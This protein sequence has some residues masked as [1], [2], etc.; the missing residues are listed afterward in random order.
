MHHTFYKA[1]NLINFYGHTETH[2]Y[3][4]GRLIDLQNESWNRLGELLYKAEVSTR[5]FNI[6]F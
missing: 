5:V 1:N 4:E 3:S 2:T 6:S